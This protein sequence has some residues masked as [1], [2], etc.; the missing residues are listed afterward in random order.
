MTRKIKLGICNNIMIKKF[1]IFTISIFFGN[2]VFSMDSIDILT[3]SRWISDKEKTVEW[4]NVHRPTIKDK[5]KLSDFFGKMIV[6]TTREEYVTE[7]GGKTNSSPIKIIGETNHEVA[8]VIKDPI[9]KR[10]VIV[11]VEIDEDKQGYWTY[12]SQFDIKEHFILYKNDL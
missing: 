3:K 4:I 6:Q 1:F 9:M 5:D 11:V 7:I 2:N 10:D 8:I 12:N